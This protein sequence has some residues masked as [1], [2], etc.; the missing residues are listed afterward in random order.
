M[1]QVNKRTV[2]FINK[3]FQGHFL[4]LIAMAFLLISSVNII[5]G[6]LFFHKVRQM[7][8]ESGI[9][10]QDMFFQFMNYQQ[11]FYL[12]VQMVTILITLSIL[13]IL[14]LHLSNKVAGPIY[15]IQKYISGDD[16]SE[17]V[18]IRE[19]DY[20]SEFADEINHF[21]QKFRAKN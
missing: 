10:A 13:G 20:F 16:F 14:G 11:S 8:S 3:K 9:D 4:F 21:V 19:G 5:S 1:N 18:K 2:L 12:V 15:R 7:A 17:P 6:F